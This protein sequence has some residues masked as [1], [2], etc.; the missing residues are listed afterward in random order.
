MKSVKFMFKESDSAPDGVWMVLGFWQV[1]C[2][3]D[4]LFDIN[5]VAIVHANCNFIQLQA[6]VIGSRFLLS[7]PAVPY[8]ARLECMS[9]A[10]EQ[11]MQLS[12]R[13]LSRWR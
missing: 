9:K 12:P 10:A 6:T 11:A 13:N 4:G 1:V 7:A 8:L 3:G 5:D 2:R